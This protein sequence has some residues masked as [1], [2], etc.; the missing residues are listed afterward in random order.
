MKPT[1]YIETSVISYL[2]A[3]PSRDLIVAAHQQITNEWWENALPK[4]DAFISPIVLEEI[5]RG[6]A[7]AARSRL[8]KVSTF[9]VLEVLPEVQAIADTY[10]SA[11][12]IPEKA[13]ADAYHLATASW[14]GI[15]FLVSWNCTHIVNGHIKMLIEEINAKQGIRTPIIC[16]PEELMEG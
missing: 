4:Y 10:F 2:T 15:D 11:L 9:P 5:S 13:R 8:E 14:H 7:D 16:T 12:T 6:D 3:K 1:V